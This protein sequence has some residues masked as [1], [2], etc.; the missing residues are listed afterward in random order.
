MRNQKF[1]VIPFKSLLDKR[2]RSF[3]SNISFKV[4][5]KKKSFESGPERGDPASM[6][7]LVM[8][9]H[10]YTKNDHVKKLHFSLVRV[11]FKYPKDFIWTLHSSFPQFFSSW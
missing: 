4:W 5:G 11:F 9:R 10:D 6:S 7:E 2:L 8:N 3:Q 1:S